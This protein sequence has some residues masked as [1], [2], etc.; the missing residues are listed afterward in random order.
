[1]IGYI[2][3]LRPYICNVDPPL[4]G[5]SRIEKIKYCEILSLIKYY[6]FPRRRLSYP[7][8]SDRIQIYGPLY[9]K[10]MH[11]P[12]CVTLH[13]TTP[14]HTDPP[15]RWTLKLNSPILLG[16]EMREP[17]RVINHFFFNLPQ[18][19]HPNPTIKKLFVYNAGVLTFFYLLEIF[20]LRNLLF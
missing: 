7:H 13:L 10:L 5:Y 4:V 19:S 11:W 15:D 20:F 16:T 9:A 18:V 17:I 2:P 14:K 8:Q 6:F 1:M 3:I 12:D